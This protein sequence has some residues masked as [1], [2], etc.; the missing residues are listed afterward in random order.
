MAEKKE[1]KEKKEKQEKKVGLRAPAR[2]S[3]PVAAPTVPLL[4]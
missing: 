2:A 1:K 4:Y 3:H